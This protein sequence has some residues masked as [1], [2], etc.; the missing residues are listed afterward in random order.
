[1]VTA[2]NAQGSQRLVGKDFIFIAI[3]GVLLFVVFFLFAMILGMNANTFWFTHALGAIPGGIVWM[4]LVAR[5]PKRGAVLIMSVLV[6]LVGLLLGMLWTGP[7]GIVV[8][9]VIAEIIM[10]IGRRSTAKAVVAFAVWTLCFWLGQQMMI[11]L[12]GSSYVDMV[13]QSGMSVEYGQTL[14]G[15]MQSPLILVAGAA[16]VVGAVLGGVLGGRVFK[17]H[18]ARIAA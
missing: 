13:V 18:F 1:M 4:Y 5:V 8:G 3:F 7:A 14:V 11:F 16:C 6:A 10:G 17:K 12:A 9:G 15:F 2:A